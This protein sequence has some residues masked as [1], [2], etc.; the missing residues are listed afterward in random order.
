MENIAIGLVLLGL[1]GIWWFWK[2]QPNKKYLLGS[3]LL[4]IVSFVIFGVTSDKTTTTQNTPP[5]STSTPAVKTTKESVSSS[6][7]T[8]SSS[9]EAEKK[10]AEEKAKKEAETKASIEA[11]NAQKAKEE[12]EKK[13]PSTYP[14]QTY[15]EM[16]RNGDSHA[17]EKLQI[18]GKVLQVQDSDDGGAT[19]RVATSADGYDDVYLVQIFSSEWKGHRLLEDD[20][21][22]IYG[23]VY[24]LYSYK[25]VL[26]NNV[27]LPAIIATFY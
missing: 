4:T 26:G 9:E 22:T 14:T 7:E 18:T 21:I 6:K 1:V 5:S 20:Q 17:G 24:G 15:D 11:A 8:S 27:T 16:A 13:D 25:T 10:A 3:M 19:L 23:T 2:Q 12:A